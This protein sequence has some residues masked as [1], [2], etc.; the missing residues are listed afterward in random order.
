MFIVLKFFSDVVV[1][2]GVRFGFRENYLYYW[3]DREKIYYYKN[4]I[5]NIN[6]FLLG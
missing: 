6:R 4:E 2:F 5:Y 3:F 1:F